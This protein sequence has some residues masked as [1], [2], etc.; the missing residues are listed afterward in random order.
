VQGAAG[1]E[2]FETLMPSCGNHSFLHPGLRLRAAAEVALLVGTFAAIWI[3]VG[4][5][6]TAAILG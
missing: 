1:W 5:V 3:S 2:A 4:S 6:L